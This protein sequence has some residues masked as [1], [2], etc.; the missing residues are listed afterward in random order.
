M[1]FRSE[2]AAIGTLFERQ[3]M[4]RIGIFLILAFVIASF[5]GCADT[6]GT[7]TTRQQSVSPKSL[8][9]VAPDSM[10]TVSITHNCTCP[11]NWNCVSYDT[12][13]TLIVIGGTGDNTAVP[14]KVDRS[15]I[16]V[17]TLNTYFL[18]RSAFGIDTVRVTVYR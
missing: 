6:S 1:I 4:N 14:V 17:D 15:K 18:V 7:S 13:G 11:F 9:Y 8:V 16:A 5:G 3:I 12:T 2:R 10:K